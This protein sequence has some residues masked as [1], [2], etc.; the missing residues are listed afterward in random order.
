VIANTSDTDVVS[1][2]LWQE[3]A[4]PDNF[5]ISKRRFLDAAQKTRERPDPEAYVLDDKGSAFKPDGQRK[6]PNI[7]MEELINGVDDD[8]DYLAFVRGKR[9]SRQHAVH[10][11]FACFFYT[12]VFDAILG[13]IWEGPEF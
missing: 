5:R 7:S 10:A 9:L 1:L 11:V 2:T 4:L 13:S 8:R 6:P 12:R 3:S